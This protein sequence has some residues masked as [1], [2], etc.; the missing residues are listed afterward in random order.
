M[1]RLLTLTLYAAVVL[2]SVAGLSQ[3]F[4]HNVAAT[5]GVCCAAS[6]DCPGQQLCYAPTH[7][8]QACCDDRAPG[9][10]NGPNYCEDKRM[11]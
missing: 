2:S 6:S 5:A 11:D 9:G 3:V 4:E 10:C 8:L 1:K 7:P